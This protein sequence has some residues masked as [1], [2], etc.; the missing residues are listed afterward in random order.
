[1]HIMHIYCWILLNPGMCCRLYSW[2]VHPGSWA[3]KKCSQALQ[4]PSW[5][6]PL[7]TKLPCYRKSPKLYG[8][9]TM[10]TRSE[11]NSASNSGTLILMFSCLG[12]CLAPHFRGSFKA[13]PSTESASL[14]AIIS[15]FWTIAWTFKSPGLFFGFWG[16]HFHLFTTCEK[17]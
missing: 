16:N 1:M 14:R 2:H 11:T 3:A 10:Q 17:M 12:L 7:V 9:L 13:T 15:A 5:N 4:N 6:F 8:T